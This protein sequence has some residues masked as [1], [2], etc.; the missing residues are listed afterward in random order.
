MGMSFL[1]TI[2]SDDDENIWPA[3]E[4]QL[5]SIC[6]C[7]ISLLLVYLLVLDWAG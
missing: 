2:S 7:D 6:A 4:V 3:N 1:A 5:E